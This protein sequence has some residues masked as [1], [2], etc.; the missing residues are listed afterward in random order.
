MQTQSAERQKSGKTC[1]GMAPSLDTRLLIAFNCA[2]NLVQK[3]CLEHRPTHLCF[4]LG[5]ECPARPDHLRCSECEEKG[6]KEWLTGCT[7]VSGELV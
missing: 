5:R 1:L 7:Q 4:R 2:E 6:G 3:R